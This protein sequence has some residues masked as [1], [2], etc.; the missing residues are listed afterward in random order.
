MIVFVTGA[1]SGFGAAI[2]RA[3]VKGGH[4]VIAAARRIERLQALADELGEALLPYALDVRDRAAVAAIPAT[5]PARFAAI[6]VLVNNAGLALG[7]E[8]AQRAALDDWQTMIDTNCT[9]L[10]QVT[11]ALLP[12]MLERN[13]GHVFNI[14][15]TAGNWPYPGGNVYGATKAFVQQFSL[16]LRADLTGTAIRVTNIEPG[17]CGGTEF[18]NIRFHGD[19]S[20]AANVYQNVQ[21]LSAED[22]A[23]SIYWI[24]T[25]P[26]HVN[27]NT[28]EL[29]PVA[30]SFASLS[31]H[32]G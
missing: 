17:L 12:G 29:M 4:Q 6:D 20:K 19:D 21:A 5:L 23:D 14:G 7:Q 1:S 15:S 16:N 27:I 3:F 18:S 30:Q 22:I 25:R 28:I 31:I 26:A 2:A 24:A 10:V 32:R 11:R 8:L 13:R 9:G